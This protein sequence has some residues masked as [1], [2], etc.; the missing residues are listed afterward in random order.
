MR[1][2]ITDKLLAENE[3]YSSRLLKMPVCICI[4]GTQ[5]MKKY[6]YDLDKSLKYVIKSIN[7]GDLQKYVD[8]GMVSYFE[9]SENKIEFKN[10]SSLEY[11]RLIFSGQAPGSGEF[12]YLMLNEITKKLGDYRINGNNYCKPVIMIITSAEKEKFS[13][14][15]KRYITEKRMN[16]AVYIISI[17]ISE[18]GDTEELKSISDRVLKSTGRELIDILSAIVESMEHQSR[19][20]TSS[21]YEELLDPGKKERWSRFLV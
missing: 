4:N 8:I 21:A 5:S 16:N 6:E 1:S 15:I 11:P 19:S 3:L 2:D 10:V 9:G 18:S 20:S 7:D 12:L 17:V 13:E 14:K